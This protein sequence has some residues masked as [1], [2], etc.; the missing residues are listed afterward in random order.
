MSIFQNL[1]PFAFHSRFYKDFFLFT[2]LTSFF[3]IKMW[4]YFFHYDI[5][6]LFFISSLFSLAIKILTSS[7]FV[8]ELKTPVVIIF[9]TSLS[10][11]LKLSFFSGLWFSLTSL[12][13][14]FFFSQEDSFH[15]LHCLMIHMSLFNLKGFL[16]CI[17]L[18][19]P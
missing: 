9:L 1:L 11:C 4:L 2:W 10:K 14:N 5:S 13:F 18:F 15:L 7:Y 3:F 16:C 8:N 6:E 19:V 12:V 17:C